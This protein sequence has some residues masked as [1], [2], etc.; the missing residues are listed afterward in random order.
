MISKDTPRKYLPI[1]GAFC[2]LLV[3]IPF[4]FA[5]AETNGAWNRDLTGP[6]NICKTASAYSPTPTPTLPQYTIEP[7][8]PEILDYPKELS[9][10]E[11]VD[12]MFG[13]P[14]VDCDGVI[15]REDNCAIT[16]NPDQADKDKNGIGDVCEGDNPKLDL[17]CDLDGDGIFDRHDNCPMVCNPDQ[18]DNNKNGTGD[19]CDWDLLDNWVRYNPC[20]KP[21]PNSKKR[22]RGRSEK[23]RERRTP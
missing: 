6:T 9:V 21:A 16:Y 11:M 5:T 2:C 23:V 15:N 20:K 13:T 10:H 12:L 8:P 3:A 22:I 7:A 1:F 4:Y 18:K 14:D 19:V 17:R